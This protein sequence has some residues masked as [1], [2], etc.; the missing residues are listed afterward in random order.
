MRSMFRPISAIAT[1]FLIVTFLSCAFAHAQLSSAAVN[2]VV[3]DPS[4]AAIPGAK[5]TLRSV[6]NG[7]IRDTLTNQSGNYVFVSVEPGNYTIE[8]TRQGFNTAT[9]NTVTLYVSQ[10][11]TFNFNLAVG[12]EV[13][14]VTVSAAAAQLESS[15]AELGT[16]IDQKEVSSL[17][18]N[19]RNLPNC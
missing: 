16:V 19:G 14:R 7:G 2:G 12:T 17:P 10:T 3:L 8:V 9:Q 15:T 4:G 5:V 13:Q 18:L 11:A 6:D 1:G